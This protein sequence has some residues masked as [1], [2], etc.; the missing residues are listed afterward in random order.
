[1]RL[2]VAMHHAFRVCALNASQQLPGK[3]QAALQ[4]QRMLR[5]QDL[6]QVFAFGVDLRS[7]VIQRFTERTAAR[8]PHFHRYFCA[9]IDLA[10]PTALSSP[11]HMSRQ[12]PESGPENGASAA[13]ERCLNLPGSCATR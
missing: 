13:L 6:I 9:F 3:F 12:G 4:R 5:F 7:Q 11:W 2:E 1:M 10:K 8:Q